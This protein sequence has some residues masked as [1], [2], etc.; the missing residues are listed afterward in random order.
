M[1]PKINIDTKS[2]V[3]MIEMEKRAARYSYHNEIQSPLSQICENSDA[4]GPLLLKQTVGFNKWV[5]S[6]EVY[7]SRFRPGDLVELRIKSPNRD[8][9]E[10]FSYD[11]KVEN[12]YYP[13]PGKI[14]VCITCDKPADADSVG[15]V[16]LFKSYSPRFNNLLVKKLED[17][18][19]ANEPIILGSD[20]YSLTW[21]DETFRSQFERLN[22]SQQQAIEYLISNNMSGAIQGPPGTG[23]T[24]L[25]NTVVALALSS[26][27]KVCVTS[28]THAAV[29]NLLGPIVSSGFDY[30]WVRIGDKDRVK[31][32]HYKDPNSIFSMVD[33]FTALTNESQLI[34]STIHKLVYNRSAPKVDLLIIDEAG[35]VPIYFWPFTQ[36][37]AKRVILVSDQFQLP[38]VLAADHKEIPFD[39]VFSMLINDETSMLRDSVSHAP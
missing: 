2:L 35:Q 5:L 14:E 18:S 12:V 25:L 1:R 17:M 26:G 9:S 31:K 20:K 13:S 8:I 23:K 11:W 34:G 19:Q 28:F 24:H 16:F 3:K 32:E 4:L 39:N 38:P 7:Y 30:S 37:L 15:E 21:K 6:G 10:H 36:R 29:D 22:R 27:M 33:G